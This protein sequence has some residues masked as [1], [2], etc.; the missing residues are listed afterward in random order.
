MSMTAEGWALLPMYW[1]RCLRGRSSPSSCP[2]PAVFSDW[3]ADRRIFESLG[4]ASAGSV[5]ISFWWISNRRNA[6]C[7]G[8]S[9]IGCSDKE[10]T[11]KKVQKFPIFLKKTLA[12]WVSFLYN[13]SARLKRAVTFNTTHPVIVPPSAKNGGQ[14][15]MIGVEDKTKG[16]F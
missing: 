11:S 14:C 7:L 8:E 3:W 10:N 1:W 9:R 15:E 13:G 12:K 6:G 16:D 2:A 5:R 4:N